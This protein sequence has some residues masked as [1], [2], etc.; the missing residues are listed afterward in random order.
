MKTFL[1]ICGKNTIFAAFF[2]MI[3]GGFGTAGFHTCKNIKEHKNI[4][5]HFSIIN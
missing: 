1:H 4:N 2:R 3:A 5:C